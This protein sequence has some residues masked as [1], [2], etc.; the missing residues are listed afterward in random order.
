[1][2]DLQDLLVQLAEGVLHGL[3]LRAEPAQLR[4]TVAIGGPVHRRYPQ[5][6]QKNTSTHDDHSGSGRV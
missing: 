4:G 3:Q 2:F 6:A 1:M 5:D